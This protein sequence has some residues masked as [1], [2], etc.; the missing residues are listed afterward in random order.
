MNLTKERQEFV[1][2]MLRERVPV[3][4]ARAVMRHAATI[5]RLAAAA[6]NGD[7]PCDNGERTVKPCSRCEAGYV[8]SALT[9]A[10]LCSSCRHADAI[11]RLLTPFNV[12][13][14]FQGDPRGACVKLIAPSG[15]TNDWGRQGICV[16]TP[17]Y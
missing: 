4:V 8:P 3:D 16:P 5:Q 6:C 1:A 7:Y 17:E 14:S 2:L 11:T 9:P 12:K 15:Y 10:G 13:P